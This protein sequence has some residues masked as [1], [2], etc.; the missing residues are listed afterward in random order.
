MRKE[1]PFVSRS[2]M[3]AGKGVVLSVAVSLLLPPAIAASDSHEVPRELEKH[4]IR[5]SR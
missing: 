4:E 5:A 2:T 1:R 3:Q